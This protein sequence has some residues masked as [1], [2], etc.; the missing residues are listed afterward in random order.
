METWERKLNEGT[1]DK[2]RN[3]RRQT[4]KEIMDIYNHPTITQIV[5]A[6]QVTSLPHVS[7]MQSNRVSKKAVQSGKGHEKEMAG[8]REDRFE[9]MVNKEMG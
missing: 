9:E 7:Q 2:G 1:K 8:S 6:K 5:K 4:N 3:W